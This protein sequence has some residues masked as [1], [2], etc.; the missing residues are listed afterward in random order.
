MNKKI[1]AIVILAVLVV[2]PLAHVYAQGVDCGTDGS[3]C[4]PDQPPAP[5]GPGGGGLMPFLARI[6]ANILKIFNIIAGGIVVIMWLW[7]GMLFMFAT[8]N[9]GNLEKGKKALLASIAGTLLVI[10]STSATVLISNAF[11][12]K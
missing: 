3:A 12:I 9:P 10:I 7:T 8:T 5:G 4:P 6:L 11:G 1:L 2:L